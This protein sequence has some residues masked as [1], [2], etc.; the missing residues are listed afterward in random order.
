[1]LDHGVVVL[2][3]MM[4]IVFFALLFLG[5]RFPADVGVDVGGGQ[6]Y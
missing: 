1:M 5:Q 2:E 3:F 4:F 6:L